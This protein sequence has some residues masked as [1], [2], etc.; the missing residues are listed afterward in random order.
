MQNVI[1]R[2]QA[3]ADYAGIC[4]TRQSFME[5]SG[6]MIACLQLRAA[7]MHAC[8]ARAARCTCVAAVVEKEEVEYICGVLGA[9]DFWGSEVSGS[10]VWGPR[11]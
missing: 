5:G 2:C 3:P 4:N 8:C 10:E 6:V 1:E 9:P 11:V 7:K